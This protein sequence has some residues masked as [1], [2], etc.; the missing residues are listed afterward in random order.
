MKYMQI[1]IVATMKYDV[2]MTNIHVTL[3]VDF[4]LFGNIRTFEEVQIQRHYSQ[5]HLSGG[6]YGWSDTGSYQSPFFL[7]KWS[8]Y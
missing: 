8:C 5:T 2:V 4:C 6:D 3:F 1:G 7:D